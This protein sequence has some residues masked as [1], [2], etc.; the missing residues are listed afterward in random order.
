MKIPTSPSSTLTTSCSVA[1]V[2]TKMKTNALW[3]EHN[4]SIQMNQV[5]TNVLR[6]LR[7]AGWAFVGVVAVEELV[8]FR[9][10]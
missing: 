3:W 5:Y 4:I 1:I 9:I 6:R 2:M 8:C 7:T 10:W